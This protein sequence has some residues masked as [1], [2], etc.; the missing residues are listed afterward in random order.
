[1]FLFPIVF[2]SVIDLVRDHH[3]KF[4]V[5]GGLIEVDK[6]AKLPDQTGWNSRVAE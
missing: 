2:M 3:V 4:Q 6:V 1:M 5:N